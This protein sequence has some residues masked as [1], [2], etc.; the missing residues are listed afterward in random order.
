MIVF[1]TCDVSVW[2]ARR[3]L[4]PLVSIQL[5]STQFSVPPAGHRNCFS[6]FGPDLIVCIRQR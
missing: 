2:L 3:Y 6:M 5:I 4:T 1:F